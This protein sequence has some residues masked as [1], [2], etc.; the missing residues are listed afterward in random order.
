MVTTR[1]RIVE[2]TAAKPIFDEC[3]R[4]LGGNS[5][6]MHAIVWVK[7]GTS[8]PPSECECDGTCKCPP[9]ASVEVSFDTTHEYRNHQGGNRGDLH[10]WLILRLGKWLDGNG[11][12]WWWEN[13]L[14]GEW[15]PSTTSPDGILGN[16]AIGAPVSRREV[17]R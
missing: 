7:Q 3:R 6:G 13:S 17:T 16:P 12:T 5:S 2:L 11:L 15:F 9:T 14:T 8:G 1:I 4:I 10:A